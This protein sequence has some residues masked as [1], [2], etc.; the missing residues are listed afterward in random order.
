MFSFTNNNDNEDLVNNI[1]L[2][3]EKEVEKDINSVQKLK[4]EFAISL[5]ENLQ[6]RKEIDLLKE[7]NNQLRT[8]NL[9]LITLIKAYKEKE[10]QLLLTEESLKNMRDEYDALKDSL[11]KERED[12]RLELRIKDNIYNTDIIQTNLRTENMKHQVDNFT[13]IKK[14]NDILYIKNQ[15]LLKNIEELKYREKI[16]LEAL[17]IRYNKKMNNYKRKMIEFL[18][19]NEK[20]RARNKSQNELNN[21]LNIL[22]IQELVNEVE[23]QGVEVEDLLKERQEL[24]F[25]ILELNRDLNIYQK[26][27]DII[28][29]KNNTFQNKLKNI[30]NNNI[31]EYNSLSLNKKKQ[32]NQKSYNLL[33]EPDKKTLNANVIKLK[34][35][36]YRGYTRNEKFIKIIKEKY[37]AKN[38]RDKLSQEPNINNKERND[39]K[40]NIDDIGNKSFK[41]YIENKNKDK[42]IEFLFKEREKYKDSSK[43][44]KDKLD[45]I[46]SKFSN[47]MKI[48]DEALEK[49]YKEELDKNIENIILNVNDFKKFDFEKMTWEQKYAILI[50]LIN[51]ISPL[52]YKEDL[53]NNLFIKSASQAKEKYKMNSFNISSQNST[54][55]PSQMTDIIN[56]KSLSNKNNHLKDRKSLGCFSD[57]KKLLNK[58]KN[59]TLY[60]FSN[61]KISK[62]LLP[63][64]DLLEL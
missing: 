35:Q 38:V 6:L 2:K 3:E 12:F 1:S 33:T 37:I 10:S 49:I 8:K 62:D 44:Y 29:K 52:I 5:Q 22:H 27:I 20:E 64:I 55:T 31:Q 60:R 28:M 15:D 56:L 4:K 9:N 61:S 21:K 14:L 26:V 45:I 7:T 58:D 18:L 57:Y 19:K 43:F 32:L 24:K 34:K 63:K 46:N 42:I 16:K 51:H 40:E 53:E 30:N 17:E 47:I 13:G 23:I 59:K 36:K 41:D 48:Y 50:K 11:L 39:N 54:K 25:K